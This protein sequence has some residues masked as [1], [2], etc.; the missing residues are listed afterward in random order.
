MNPAALTVTANNQVKTY[1]QT[2]TFTGTEFTPTGLQNGET[3]GSVTLASS[4]A[5]ATAHVVGSPYAITRARPTGGTFTPSDYAISYVH[6]GA[7]GEHGGADGDGEQPVENVWSDVH[8]HRYGVHADGIAKQR[9]GGQ[10]D[11]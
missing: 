2:F 1:G 6:R 9:D 7:D 5:A 10:R 4:G 8:V 11:T 3:V